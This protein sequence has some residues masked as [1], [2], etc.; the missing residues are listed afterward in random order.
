MRV[1]MRGIG[2]A[3]AALLTFFTST[4]ARAE[5][6]LGAPFP[7]QIGMPE[8][9]STV[10][11]DIDS[12]HTLLLWI[13][14]P[15]SLFVLA[16]LAI[17]VVRFNEKANPVPS[18]TTHHTLLEVAWTIIPVLILVII[19]IP[20]F[21][22]LTKELVIPKADITLKATGKQWYWTYEYPKDQ[23]GGFSY[24]S[25]YKK[26]ADLNDFEKQHQLYLLAVDNEL[27]VP[28]HKT[29]AMTITADPTGVIHS[30]AV[31]ELGIRVDAVP[32]RANQTWFNADKEGVYY[33]QCSKLC[34]K[35][36]AFMPIAVRVVSQEKYDA[37]LQDAKKKFASNGNAAFASA[38]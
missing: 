37:W 12:F 7:G 9:A 2:S 29:V 27:V 31:R 8:P 36:H 11:Q 23:A 21:R 4:W 18:K 30:F 38:Q 19:A 22:L 28:V 14:I 13:I 24:D 17:I 34:G 5:D 20:S 1:N 10:A 33:G 35:D 32:G 3:A 26:E 16:L 25:N 15:I 6:A